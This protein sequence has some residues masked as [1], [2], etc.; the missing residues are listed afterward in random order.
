MVGPHAVEVEGDERV[1]Q[2]AADVALSVVAQ[3]E[4]VYIILVD[5]AHEVEDVLA[6]APDGAQA[7]CEVA[8]FSHRHPVA[9]NLY[10]VVAV[11]LLVVAA[12][13]RYRLLGAYAVNPVD[14]HVAQV[15]CGALLVL[16]AHERTHL[17][18]AEG[19]SLHVG[20]K[21]HGLVVELHAERLG[22][23]GIYGDERR[24]TLHIVVVRIH[25]AGSQTEH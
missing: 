11:Q 9:H 23:D 8:V 7:Q 19:R 3:V 18:I 6:A 21:E 14:A 16:V 10:A 5:A 22:G 24:R 1:A 4:L 12:L 15:A 2:H 20:R 13:R 25:I 17:L